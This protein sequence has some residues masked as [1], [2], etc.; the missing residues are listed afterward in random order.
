ME[1]TLLKRQLTPSQAGGNVTRWVPAG[2]TLTAK[3]RELEDEPEAQGGVTVRR[4]VFEALLKGEVELNPTEH[5]LLGP[6]DVRYAVLEARGGASFTRAKLL[7]VRG[8]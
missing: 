7:V 5:R 8:G 3:L 2:Q 4:R 1:L 6:D